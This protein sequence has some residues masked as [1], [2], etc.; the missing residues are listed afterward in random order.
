MPDE[1]VELHLGRSGQ[2]RS[3]LTGELIDIL[4]RLLELVSDVAVGNEHLKT[5]PAL[6][7]QLG[8]FRK[9]LCG[10]PMPEP[11]SLEAMADTCI[12]AC[13]NFF[14]RAREHTLN[15]EIEFIEI[16]DVLRETVQKLA[17]ESTR[18]SQSLIGSSERFQ[19]LLG[20]EDL[21]TIKQ[22]IRAEVQTLN[23][24]VEE[25]QRTDQASYSSL[26]GRIETLQHR[27]ERAEEDAML[28]PLTQV[29]NRGSFDGTIKDWVE[30]KDGAG[31]QFTLGMIDL[32][33][34]KKINDQFGHQVGDR[35]LLGAA[36][37][38]GAS[39]RSGDMVARYGGEEF[40]ILLRN[41]GIQSAEE[42]INRLLAEIAATQY[43]YSAGEASGYVRFTI[44]C[45]VAEFIEGET[46]EDIIRRADEALYEAKR[47]GKNRVVSRKPSRLRGLF[48]GRRSAA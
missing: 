16:I 19:V 44:S 14:S 34:F 23:R 42:R 21:Q 39:V 41:C 13:E 8:E 48:K 22:R 45:G 1:L 12:S 33:D 28:D 35:V 25:K 15:R 43:E 40:A 29:A 20:I 24:V 9:A 36:Q 47:T 5:T 11:V 10:R 32:D 46:V 30:S 6:R 7:S 38:F 2:S 17:G 27:L 26:S 3:D 18:F 4:D 31:K 37:L